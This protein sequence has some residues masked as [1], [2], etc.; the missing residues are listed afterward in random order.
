MM[1]TTH[2]AEPVAALPDHIEAINVG[3]DLFAEALQAQNASVTSVDWRIPAGGDPSLVAALRRLHGIHAGRIA[4]ANAE[5]LHRLD[6]GIP[7]LVDITNAGSAVPEMSPRTLLHPGPAITLEHVCDPLLR[8]MRAAIIAEGWASD[9][10]GAQALLEQG[11]IDLQPANEHHTVVPMA[12]ALGPTQPVYAVRDDVGGA[13]AYAALNQG[14]GE[15]A[16]FGRETPAAI[17]RLAFLRETVAPVLA[18]VLSRS[19]P[20]N[21]LAMAAEAVAMGDDVHIRAQ[22]ATNLLIRHWLPY[23]AASEA[24][25]RV[26]VAE[27]LAGNHLFFLN[28]AMAAARTL[29]ESAAQVTDASI[30]TTMARNG[31]TFGIRL[32]GEL[33][34]HLAE[35]PP[36]G[37]ALYYQDQ[38]PDTSAP[39]IGDSAVLELT[40]LGGSA[41]AGSP[42][43]AHVVGG[44][45]TDAQAITDR[46]DA[47]CL[48][49]SSR[50]KL[51]TLGMRG[52][53]FGLDVRNVVETGITP[54]ITTGIL[55]NS[56]GTGQV[57]VG[58][59]EA[60]L[61]CFTNALLAL[62]DR[63][64]SRPN[65]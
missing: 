42:S 43:V 60:P 47:G 31:T 3:L 22:A 59:A 27:F 12:T 8:S 17:A 51:P 15:V 53:P 16:W 50:F 49:R 55:H 41:A 28:L 64:S 54:G 45:M 26:D 36:V 7:M 24:A 37:H 38:G 33:P 52:T 46:M 65:H 58:I 5:V 35:A 62:D 57:G 4:T 32:A 18:D 2:A 23:L 61:D 30:V 20:V 13:T 9:P 44:S 6:E 10:E 34:W 39:D 11:A 21:V 48:G 1:N 29:T 25:G 56:A 14:P 40:G 19:G 63:L